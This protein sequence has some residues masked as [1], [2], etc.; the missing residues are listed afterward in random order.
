LTI[1]LSAR[2]TSPCEVS[3]ADNVALTFIAVS[4]IWTTEIGVAE[5]DATKLDFQ[6]LL[7]RLTFYGHAADTSGCVSIPLIFSD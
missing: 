1:T 3:L 2:R 5:D 7:C 4:H 6:T